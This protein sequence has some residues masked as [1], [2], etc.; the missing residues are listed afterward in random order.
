MRGESESDPQGRLN[1]RTGALEYLYSERTLTFLKVNY[2]YRGRYSRLEDLRRE[3]A[4]R[5]YSVSTSRAYMIYNRAFLVFAGVP[6]EEIRDAHAWDFLDYMATIRGSRPATIRLIISALQFYFVQVRRRDP[7]RLRRPGKDR[8]L[9]FVLSRE[10]V[11]RILRTPT[12]R[13]HRV[14]LALIYSCGLRVSEASKM[15]VADL[16]F[17]RSVVRIR[18]G[19]GRKDR[20]TILSTR[21]K[22]ILK[23]YF[24]A[25]P[26]TQWLFPGQDPAQ[27]L[28]IRSIERIFDIACRKAEIENDV[29]VHDLRHAFAT[30]LLE[31]G[32]DLRYIQKLLGHASSRTT[33][34]YTH[35]SNTTL[36]QI[37]SP[38]DRT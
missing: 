16:D 5:K 1:P 25:K 29:S 37:R 15:R 30:H 28:S 18:S 10:E 12:N 17:D 19:K 34:I 21:L 23:R 14:V 26:V 33:E 24:D 9:P 36:T 6:V 3:L 13:K 31:S 32:T 22:P 20:Y 8:N 2:G 35:V 38:L 27:P 11:M 4:I 7:F